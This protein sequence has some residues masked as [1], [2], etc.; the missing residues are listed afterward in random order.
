MVGA[1]LGITA[2]KVRNYNKVIKN[3]MM[4][5]VR[6]VLLFVSTAVCTMYPA[7]T[8]TV[9]YRSQ[10]IGGNSRTFILSNTPTAHAV[11]SLCMYCVKM[12]QKGKWSLFLLHGELCKYEGVE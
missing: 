3:E 5:Y 8:L 12:T 9:S 4:L 7:G 1:N 10:Y 11:V 2:L 6:T